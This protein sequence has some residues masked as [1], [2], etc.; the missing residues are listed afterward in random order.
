MTAYIAVFV[1]ITNCSW[2]ARGVGVG[3]ETRLAQGL[4]VLVHSSQPKQELSVS[5]FLAQGSGLR[6]PV[7]NFELALFHKALHDPLLFSEPL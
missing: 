2:N 3:V 4:T 6:K 5:Q 7:V 1:H